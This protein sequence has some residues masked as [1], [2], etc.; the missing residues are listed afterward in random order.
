MLTR[1]F[2]IACIVIVCGTALLN[3]PPVHAA[4]HAVYT[5]N[6]TNDTDDGVCNAAHC[7]LR[8]AIHAAN[9]SG[10]SGVINF[11]ILGLPP[12]V[13]R[14]ASPLPAIIQNGIQIDGY[15]QP[16]AALNTDWLVS[17][18]VILIQ[19][20]G[21]LTTGS[22]LLLS[23][24]NGSVRG[25][26]LSGW[27]QAIVLNSNY[28]T[29]AGNFIGILPDGVTAG[30]ND[31]GVVVAVGASGNV[32]GGDIPAERNVISG[33]MFYGVHAFGSGHAIS[34][35]LI[36]TDAS[37]AVA[38]ANGDGI[39]LGATNCQIRDNVISGN[40]GEGIYLG[41]SARKNTIIRNAIGSDA[42][43]VFGIGN[44]R[45]GVAFYDGAKN[46]RVGG[47]A[48]DG[49]LIAFNGGSGIV[50]GTSAGKANNLS[51]NRIVDNLD[52]GIDLNQNGVTP[53]DKLDAD[54]GPNTLQNYPQ[55]TSAESTPQRI[56]GK[57][58][59]TPYAIVTLD[60]YANTNCDGSGFGEGQFYLGRFAVT[61]NARGVA[62]FNWVSPNVFF[63][64]EGI[65]VTATVKKNTSE[66]SACVVA[67]PG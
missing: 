26:S 12:F 54:G 9:S 64:G 62:K 24:G 47:N 27:T 39:N 31:R 35:N 53:N 38:V 48:N 11:N 8:E 37:G 45:S 4:P 41:G 5:V 22:G 7:S 17:N 6:T 49:N 19:L 43:R 34:N 30:A 56:R 63:T 23:G 55:I 2:A 14:P 33:N 51:A 57:I 65:T 29:V 16:G 60:F 59:T 61:T 58:K 3:V 15:S 28:N 1:S 50:L 67:L 44:S 46:N 18:A 10:A 42:L 25:L 40:N 66:F 13:I 36:G 20:N 52:L 32:I 21:A